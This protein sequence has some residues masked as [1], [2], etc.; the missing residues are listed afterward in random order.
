VID[1]VTRY[2][3]TCGFT[4]I[5]GLGL[6]RH[7]AATAVSIDSTKGVEAEPFLVPDL[8]MSHTIPFWHVLNNTNQ[9]HLPTAMVTAAIS[10][11]EFALTPPEPTINSH[12]LFNH[13]LNDFSR[14][15]SHDKGIF[16]YFLS[17]S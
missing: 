7:V 9:E 2:T 12:H 15:P 1:S 14:V 6:C 10:N 8:A 4:A 3:C 11:C 13:I 16:V 17:F 5:T